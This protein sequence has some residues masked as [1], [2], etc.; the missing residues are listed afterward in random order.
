VLLRPF[1]NRGVEK[2]SF[3]DAAIVVR[4]APV[5]GEVV[6]A[7]QVHQSL[8]DAVAISGDQHVAPA[9]EIGVCGS[10]ARQGRAAGLAPMSKVVV[11]RNQA[12]H[13]SEHRL[14]QRHIDALSLSA[15]LGSMMQRQQDA[16]DGI[17]S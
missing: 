5:V 16:D 10:D 13:H 12:F 2:G 4:K 6:P 11:L 3:F 17:E 14:I 9:A 15:M 1:L 7:Y 8:K